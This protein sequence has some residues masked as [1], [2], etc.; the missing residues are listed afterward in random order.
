[1]AEGTAWA[2]AM[3]AVAGGGRA[4]SQEWVVGLETGRW[5]GHRPRLLLLAQGSARF[6]FFFLNE[7]VI[8]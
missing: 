8:D 1:M 7:Y 3:R 2:E 4:G 6:K 5:A